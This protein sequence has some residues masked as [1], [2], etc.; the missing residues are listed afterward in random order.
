ML[1]M[2]Q[3]KQECWLWLLAKVE[4][5]SSQRLEHKKHWYESHWR[6]LKFR[7]RNWISHNL[8]N[9]NYSP[10]NVR[11]LINRFQRNEFMDYWQCKLWHIETN[12]IPLSLYAGSRVRHRQRLR[13]RFGGL[14]RSKNLL[15]RNAMAATLESA[16]VSRHE[17]SKS[18]IEDAV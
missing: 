17:R 2:N 1:R 4:L 11:V 16:G 15:C 10:L 3:K 7:W 13:F 14:T 12:R 6:Q 8:I 5:I 18:F 9:C